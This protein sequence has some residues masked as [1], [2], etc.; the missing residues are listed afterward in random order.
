MF[1]TSGYSE[2]QSSEHW[3]LM[4]LIGI[5]GGIATVLFIYAYR[6][7]APSS[8]APFEYLGIPS[9]FILGWI[10]FNEAP[11]DQLFPGVIGI[12]A[13][14]MIVIWRDRKFSEFP[15]KTKKIY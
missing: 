5:S 7:V 2:I 9:S 4:V 12:I 15:E 13:A 10:F 11:I 1:L 3:I 14:G 6:L 8:L